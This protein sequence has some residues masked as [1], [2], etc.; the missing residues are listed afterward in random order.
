MIWSSF[1]EFVHMGGYG[2]YVW[3][4]LGGTAGLML[5]EMAWVK[6]S[7]SAVVRQITQEWTAAAVQAKEAQP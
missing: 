3:G 4:S 2:L 5:I 6:Q 7:R 1:S